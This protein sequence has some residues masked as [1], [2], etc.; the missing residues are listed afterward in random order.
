MLFLD[1]LGWLQV[2]NRTRYMYME[3]LLDES[4]DV[5]ERGGKSRRLQAFVVASESGRGTEY[6]LR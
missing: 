6:E 5:H 1:L 2:C 4:R 3:A